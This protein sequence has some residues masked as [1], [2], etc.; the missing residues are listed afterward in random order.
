MGDT[1]RENG[2]EELSR[3][4][5]K[6]LRVTNIFIISIEVMVSGDINMSKLIKLYT[7][8]M[9]TSSYVDNTPNKAI[10][11]HLFIYYYFLKLFFLIKKNLEAQLL[12]TLRKLHSTLLPRT[13][14]MSTHGTPFH[15]AASSV[16]SSEDRNPWLG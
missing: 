8:N 16:T 9:C 13:F 14:K 10:F 11:I 2:R 5:R 15:A 12:N 4:T 3:I 1:G 6:L 7:F